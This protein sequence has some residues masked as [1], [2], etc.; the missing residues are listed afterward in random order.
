MEYTFAH[1][2]RLINPRQRVGI[3][4][5]QH[6]GQGYKAGNDGD[7]DPLGHELP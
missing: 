3:H 1:E 5:L 2:R 4:E 6:I 7:H